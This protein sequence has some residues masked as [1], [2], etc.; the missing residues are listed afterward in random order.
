MTYEINITNI[1][2]RLREGRAVIKDTTENIIMEVGPVKI[3]CE[4]EEEAYRYVEKTFLPDIR[5]N[6]PRQLSDLVFPWEEPE[7]EVIE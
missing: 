2:D 7:P 5:R 4:S 3:A 1:E 6:Y